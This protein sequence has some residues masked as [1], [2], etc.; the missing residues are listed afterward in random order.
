[1]GWKFWRRDEQT[2]DPQRLLAQAHAQ[3]PRQTG[4]Q[5]AM[6]FRMTIEDVFSI[7]GRGT[8]VTGRVAAGTVAKGMPVTVS[9]A[10]QPLGT[11]VV[12]GVEMFRKVLDTATAGDN[13]GLL[14]QDVTRDQ[15]QSGDEISG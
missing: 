6:P 14:L 13:V 10:G 12:T 11:T 1:M 9:R 2:M 5:D 7:T 15:V 8:V 3:Q 4:L